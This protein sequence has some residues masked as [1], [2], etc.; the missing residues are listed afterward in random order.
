[1][2]ILTR[3]YMKG[4]SCDIDIKLFIYIITVYDERYCYFFTQLSQ[5]FGFVEKVKGCFDVC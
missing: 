3:S 4:L 1:M 5:T 2:G